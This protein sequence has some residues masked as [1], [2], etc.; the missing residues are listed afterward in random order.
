MTMFSDS[1]CQSSINSPIFGQSHNTSGST[2]ATG[3]GEVCKIDDLRRVFLNLSQVAETI[4]AQN[5]FLVQRMT[6]IENNPNSNSNSTYPSL[7]MDP[8]PIIDPSGVENKMAHLKQAYGVMADL[9]KQALEVRN[10]DHICMRC[11]ENE[12][13]VVSLPCAHVGVCKVCAK[14]TNNCFLCGRRQDSCLEISFR[15]Q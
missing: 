8:S 1:D 7:I 5:A 12:R 4:T 11:H 14:L 6:E 9:K 3:G 10:L 2:Q 13:Q 15:R